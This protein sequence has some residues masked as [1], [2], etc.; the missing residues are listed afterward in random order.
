MYRNI[1]IATD[2]SELAERAVTVGLELAKPLEAKVTVVTVTDIFP[3]AQHAL[4]PRPADIDWYEARAAKS[5]AEILDRVGESAREMGIACTTQHVADEYPAQGI[6]K[7]CQEHGCDLIVM[8]THG[9]RGLDKLLLGSQ[10]AKV[11]TL[12]SVP[13]LICR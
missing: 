13:V 4:F 12:S 10:S 6:L 9:R 1:L 8:A 3:T 5:A 7:A 2:G 11:V